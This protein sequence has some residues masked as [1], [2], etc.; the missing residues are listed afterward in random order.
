MAHEMHIKFKYGFLSREPRFYDHFR[1]NLGI[2]AKVL[3]LHKI[4]NQTFIL[5]SLVSYKSD[6]QTEV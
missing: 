3:G 6:L 1:K 2:K 4:E 5:K